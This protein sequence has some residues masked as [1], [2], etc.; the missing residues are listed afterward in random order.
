M[1]AITKHQVSK[2][3][4]ADLTFEQKNKF[5][6]AELDWV[7]A[8]RIVT[9]LIGPHTDLKSHRSQHYE[10]VVA[11][12]KQIKPK[13]ILEIGT[14]D[15]SFTAFL[16]R[17]FPDSI[18]ETIDLP[19][20]DQRFW[21][22]TDEEVGAAKDTT[23]L[24]KN[25]FPELKIRSANLQS[26]PNIRFREMNSLRLSRFDEHKF[27]LIWVDGDHTFPV[28]ACD[29]SN[30]IRLLEPDGV[31]MCD[32]I[33]FSDVQ[34]SRWGKQESYKTL[35]AFEEANLIQTSFVLKSIRPEKNYS[36]RVTKHL[37]VVKLKE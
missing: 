28:V 27:D 7:Y 21:N 2:I 17:A 32:D 20:G 14:A 12:G 25:E 8:N 16:A 11:I 30:A 35:G 26:S 37:A 13:R 31:M 23:F 34:K 19:V 4:E 5:Q 33:I 36:S 1:R 10:L 18:V 24:P 3:R 22:A 29:I 6:E 9:E 15:A